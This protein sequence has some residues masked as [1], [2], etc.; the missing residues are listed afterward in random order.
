MRIA[1]ERPEPL[2]DPELAERI[3]AR[4]LRNGGDLA[5]L[6]CEQRGSLGLAIDESRVERVQRGRDSGAGVRVV[7][8]ETTYFAHVDGLAEPDLERAADAAAA[9]LSG[10]RSEAVALRAAVRPE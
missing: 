4:A 6:F 3:V 1:L 10:D 8:G 2:I 7:S 5:E 9:A